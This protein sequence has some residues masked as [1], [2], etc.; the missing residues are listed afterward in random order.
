MILIWDNGESYGSEYTYLIDS[1][2]IPE[3]DCYTL[4]KCRNP[5]GQLIAT[6]YETDIDWK[7][8]KF[9]R[10][11]DEHVSF[12][13]LRF[14]AEKKIFNA[15]RH[16]TLLKCSKQ[17]EADEKERLELSRPNSKAYKTLKNRYDNVFAPFMEAL[18]IKSI[19][20]RL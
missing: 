11:I 17:W 5:K 1:C 16:S 15:V 3:D 9:I 4:L 7:S 14:R 10:R 18:K 6:A 2:G 19:T 8:K 13:T 12:W 20:S